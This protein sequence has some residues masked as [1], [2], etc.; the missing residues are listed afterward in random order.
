M[1]KVT[2]QVAFEPGGWTPERAAKVGELFDGLAPDWH[3]QM[4]RFRHVPLDD[5]L[6]R[7]G[8]FA[9]GPALEVGSGTG[10]FTPSLRAVWPTVVACDL[11]MEMLLRAPAEGAG[12]VRADASRLP[13]AGTTFVAA[14]LVNMLLFPAEMDRVL[15]PH[16][17]LIWVNTIGDA[18]PIHLSAADV[19]E[20]LPGQWGGV[21]AEAG[22][23]TWAAL[24]RP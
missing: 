8:P 22:W 7:G 14:V 23:G 5:A 4:T 13:F 17:T 12:R 20:A 6:T 18:T 9:P 19:A 24:R 16:G 21:H 11:S 10:L 3:N 2:R 1:R 15:A